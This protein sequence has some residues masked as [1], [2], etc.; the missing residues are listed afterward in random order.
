[1]KSF[2]LSLTCLCMCLTAYAQVRFDRMYDQGKHL[3]LTG[4][5]Q[6]LPGEGYIFSAWRGTFEE[7]DTLNYPSTSIWI[8]KTDLNGDTLWTRTY[9]KKHFFY[10]VGLI[11]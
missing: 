5:V 9:Q 6:Y 2:I 10:S 8:V 1:M 3:E 4:G 7:P 11:Q